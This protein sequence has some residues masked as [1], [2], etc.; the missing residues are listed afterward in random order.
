[1]RQTVADR[2]PSRPRRRPAAR[3]LL[4]ALAAVLAGGAVLWLRARAGER[5]EA[6]L[7]SNLPDVVLRDRALVKAAVAEA[8]PLYLQHCAACHGAKLQGNSTLG[9]PCLTAG[10][11]L[12]G[13]GTVFDIERT[14]MYGIRSGHPKSRN[15]TDMPP[16]GLTGMLG[17]GQIREVAQYVLELGGSGH[18]GEAALAGRQPYIEHC[19]DCHGADGRGNP[20]YGAPDLTAGRWNSG[21]DA[22]S[23]YRSIYYGRHGVM[24][25]W[26][27]KLSL[28]QIRALAVYVHTMSHSPAAGKSAC[29]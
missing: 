26:L 14:L 15:V 5:L 29:R 11:W 6:R 25:G 3:W 10:V 8:R 19:T 12:Y 22:D 7:L 18:D 27:G 28:V 24:P 9:A 23:L 2:E 1:M 16:L 20:D 4:V 21:G 13:T 17:P